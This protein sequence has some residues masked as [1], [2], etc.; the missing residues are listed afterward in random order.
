MTVYAPSDATVG[1]EPT[2]V[3]EKAAAQEVFRR[4]ADGKLPDVFVHRSLAH[5]QASLAHSESQ[6]DREEW[7]GAVQSWRTAVRALTQ[8]A[9]RLDLMHVDELTDEHHD[10]VMDPGRNTVFNFGRLRPLL[11]VYM[12]AHPGVRPPN[13]MGSTLLYAAKP[14]CRHASD[15]RYS[16]VGCKH[17]P[18]WFCF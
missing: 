1:S 3:Q 7:H 17:C 12:K 15:G 16:G 11:T 4:L 8:K 9:L 6:E 2:A 10:L 18:G 13:M 14:G 5:A